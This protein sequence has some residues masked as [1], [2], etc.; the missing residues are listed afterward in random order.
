MT[1]FTAKA[2]HW[3]TDGKMHIAIYY[4]HEQTEPVKI[5]MGSQQR[6]MIEKQMEETAPVEIPCA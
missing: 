6:R 3:L 2:M 1:T 4:V 5:V